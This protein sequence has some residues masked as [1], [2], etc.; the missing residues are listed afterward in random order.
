MKKKQNS[1]SD[2]DTALLALL[3]EG[4]MHPWQLEKNVKDRDM[5]FWTGLSQSTIY[6]Q[7]RALE[8][9][10]HIACSEEIQSGR[11]RKVY[12]VTRKGREAL[13]KNLRLFLSEPEHLKYRIDLGTYNVDL[14]PPKQALDALTSYRQKLEEQIKG[15]G[16]LEKFLDSCGCPAHRKAVARRPIHL[17]KGE[18]EWVDEYLAYLKGAARA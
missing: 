11:L 3:C 15:Y 2:A 14:L 7:L 10:G 17:F 4:P 13:K 18:I 12:T 5:R 1:L 6:K 8:R 9:V 16:E